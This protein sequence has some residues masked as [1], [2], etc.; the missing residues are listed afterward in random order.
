[1]HINNSAM[2]YLVC[3]HEW[4]FLEGE[5]KH[6]HTLKPGRHLFPFQLQIGG[7][8]PSSISTPVLGGASVAYKLRAVAVR[9]GLSHNIQSQIPVYI[10]RS[11]TPEALEYQQTLEI[12]NTWPEKIM[13]SIMIPH[14][15]WAAGDTLTAVV[16]F[17]PLAKGSRVISVGTTLNETTKL[18]A[19]NGWQETTRAIVTS[20]HDIIDGHAV[21]TGHQNS[22]SRS[23]A[24]STPGSRSGASTPAYEGSW[25]GRQPQHAS[26]QPSYFASLP[27]SVLPSHHQQQPVAGSSTAPT[28][29]HHPQTSHVQIP[30]D[31]ELSDQDVVTALEITIP[32]SAIPTHSLEPIIL[33]HRIRWSILIS[34]LDG[35]TSEL[36]CSLPL[37]IL[38]NRLID[39]ALSATAVTRRLL[40]GGPEVPDS[41]QSNEMELPSY[42]SH[43]RDRVANMYLPE[44]AVMRVTNPWVQ[45][46]VSPVYRDGSLPVSGLATPLEAHQ[47]PM[48]IQPNHPTNLE[49]V[50]SEL[51]LSLSSEAPP[52]L[53]CSIPAH[54][55]DHTSPS[56]S[57][58]PSTRVSRA[59]SRANSRANSRTASPN[60]DAHSAASDSLNPPT[61]ATSST[62]VHEHSTASRNLHGVFL[63]SMK[64]FTTLA[65]PF[66]MHHHHASASAP[67]TPRSG[68]GANTP[69]PV[70]IMRQAPH[71]S[72]SLLHRAFT[73]V[74]D[75][76]VAAR[77][78]LGGITPLE[79]QQGLPSYEASETAARATPPPGPQLGSS[80]T[81]GITASSRSSSAPNL[82]AHFT[83]PHGFSPASSMLPSSSTSD[84]SSR[85]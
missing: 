3:N 35:H 20:K 28:H 15:A 21:C 43:V 59:A 24:G 57:A 70:Q 64:P 56:Q 80:H 14:K 32:I 27:G 79:S 76:G 51:L 17:S 71:T 46:G 8:L 81:G 22:S 39:E 6:S 49:Y 62:Y 75:Y 48:H 74:P 13:Y 73:E 16:K 31:F 68:P 78:F 25:T 42:S 36:R 77:G 54:S 61:L 41:A 60:R 50:N 38:D 66:R 34:N 63:N 72:S 53:D 83:G 19:R 44:Q 10:T 1:M 40:L 23:R 5:K 65:H 67:T 30:I 2:T 18:F 69:A 45:Q 47:L 84:T 26:A 85:S 7:S 4:S 37:H 58:G 11:F 52:V 82:A 12:E 33:S 55:P 29:D 9:P